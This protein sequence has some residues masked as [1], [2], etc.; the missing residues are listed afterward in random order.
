MWTPN[1]RE[2]HSRKSLRYQSDLTDAEWAVI[3]PYSPPVCSRGCLCVWP[4]CEIING[5]F[6]VVRAGCPNHDFRNQL[7]TY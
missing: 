3:A 4:M 1:A 6:C 2:Q 5:I 7:L